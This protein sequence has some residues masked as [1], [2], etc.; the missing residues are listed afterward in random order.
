M[1]GHPTG[2]Y[3]QFIA[4][5]PDD[6]HGSSDGDAVGGRAIICGLSRA[7]ARLAWLAFP[8]GRSRID[9]VVDRVRE[10]VPGVRVVDSRR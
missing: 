6:V 8:G 7:Q 9:D 3:V 1:P 5:H 10:S 4:R 2:T